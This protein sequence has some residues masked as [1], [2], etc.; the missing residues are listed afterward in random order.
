MTNL[1]KRRPNPRG[2]LLDDI[3]PL[4]L[5]GVG[6]WALGTGALGDPNAGAPSFEKVV[7][8]T[9]A[10]IEAHPIPA[11]AIAGLIL[12]KVLR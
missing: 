8:K 5:V 11:M 2:S 3:A 10:I 7:E 9:A 1:T 6:A 4:A 12:L